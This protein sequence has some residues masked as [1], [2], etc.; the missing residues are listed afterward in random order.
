VA[1][2][3]DLQAPILVLA[4]SASSSPKV[5]S[6]PRIRSTDIVLDVEQIRRRAPLLGKHTT[7]TMLDGA[8]HDVILSAPAVRKHAYEEMDRFLTYVAT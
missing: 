5:G 2:G 3:L 8:V 4:S 1:Q 7:V 6:D